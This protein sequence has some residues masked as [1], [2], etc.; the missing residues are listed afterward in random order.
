MQADL[1]HVERAAQGDRAAF[2]A[3]YD[4][5]SA[6]LFGY[7]VARLGR[8]DEAQDALHDAFLAAWQRLPSLRDTTRFVPWLFVVA[9]NA[10]A[11]IQRS[12]V[13]H[14]DDAR[15][16]RVPRE[17]AAAEVPATAQADVLP[18][19]QGLETE[20]RATLI[21][22][23]VSGL[24]VNSTAQVLDVSTATVKRRTAAGLTHLRA[25]LLRS[26]SHGR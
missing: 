7:L 21:L 8:R 1:D 4:V 17:P 10:A 23:F 25:R 5:W 16:H 24:D 6:P 9:R 19:L 22:R 11:A 12:T 3:L 15:R 26:S 14:A 2:A 13:K 20:V 18:D